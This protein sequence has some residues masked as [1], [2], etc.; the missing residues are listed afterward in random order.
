MDVKLNTIYDDISYN[1]LVQYTY[2]ITG[3]T[4]MKCKE[5]FINSLWGGKPKSFIFAVKKSLTTANAII[6]YINKLENYLK[7]KPTTFQIL[8]NTNEQDKNYLFLSIK[9]SR[10]WFRNKILLSL[11]LQSLRYTFQHTRPTKLIKALNKYGINKYFKKS[12]KLPRWDYLCNSLEY[13]INE[14]GKAIRDYSKLIVNI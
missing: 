5:L 14:N 10:G 11:F 6:E 8:N 2:S 12:I 13:E 7:I 9:I 4:W 1:N 3:C